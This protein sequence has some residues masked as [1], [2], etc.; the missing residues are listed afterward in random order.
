MQDEIVPEGRPAFTALPQSVAFT[1]VEAGNHFS[2]D[3]ILTNV[4]GA[5]AYFMVNSHAL[6]TLCLATDD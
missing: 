3:I 5:P 4:S 6:H 2:K 1:D